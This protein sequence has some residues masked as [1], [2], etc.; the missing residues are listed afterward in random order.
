VSVLP[1]CALLATL[2]LPCP[3]APGPLVWRALVLGLGALYSP[4]RLVPV[5]EA[6]VMLVLMSCAAAMMW[7][8]LAVMSVALPVM[9]RAL[10]SWM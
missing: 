6:P 7:G 4:R 9:T 10:P 5:K 3:A 1:Q 8:L 2:L